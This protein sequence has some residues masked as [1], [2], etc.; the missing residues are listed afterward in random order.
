MHSLAFLAIL[1]VA[2]ARVFDRV[3]AVPEGWKLASPALATDKVTLKIGLKQQH[4][5]ALEQ[6]V[7]A[8]STPGNP[9]YGK[10]LSREELRSY[11][12]P[13]A[14][15]T[16]EVSAWLAEYDIVPRVDNDWMTITANVTTA[17]A[18]LS[19]NFNWYE[20][21]GGGGLKLRTLSYSVPDAVAPHV[22]LVQPTTRFGSLGAARSTI[23]NMTILE[24]VEAADVKLGAT[25]VAAAPCTTTVTPACLKALYN[26][27]YT[28]TAYG[29]LVAFASYLEQ[30]ARYSDQT[31]FQQ[32]YLPEALGQNFSVTLINGGL[33]DQESPEDS[34]KWKARWVLRGSECHL[35]I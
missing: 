14:R 18:L 23:F 12:A 25:K 7:L 11:V 21:A 8:I 31:L 30:Y 28:P 16:D 35:L 3:P 17:N 22:D 32:R 19:A 1:G 34:G 13:T 29:N 4:A 26:I 2:T 24:D 6:T 20:Y 27:G 9:D 10:H 15:A 33:D 5:A